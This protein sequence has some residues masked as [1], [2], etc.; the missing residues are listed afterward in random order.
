MIQA[1]FP[2][3]SAQ[4]VLMSLSLLGTCTTP[5]HCSLVQGHSR[6]QAAVA[7]PGSS[8]GMYEP[9]QH[10][11]TLPHWIAFATHSPSLWNVLCQKIQAFCSVLIHFWSSLVRLTGV[12]GS[13]ATAPS[14][15]I[16]LP[17]ASPMVA[18]CNSSRAPSQMMGPLRYLPP[19]LV[20]KPAPL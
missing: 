20:S 11:H 4:N 12:F 2:I 9:S 6:I 7:T 19:L 3:T 13:T 18:Q 17:G 15:N 10:I 16:L 14:N 8:W 5:L 1:K